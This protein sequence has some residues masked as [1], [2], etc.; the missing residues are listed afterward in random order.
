M[1]TIM[2]SVFAAGIFAIAGIANAQNTASAT[3]TANATVICPITIVNQSNLNFGNVI[4]GNGTATVTP[5]GTENY[6]GDIYAGSGSGSHS[7]AQFLV[8]GQSSA[9]Y[10]ITQTPL[11]GLLTVTDGAGH[12]A[13][14]QLT[15]PVAQAGTL[16]TLASCDGGTGGTGGDGDINHGNDGHGGTGGNGGEDNGNHGQG[17]NGNGGTGGT[18]GTGNG[19]C[20]TQTFN[21]GGVLTVAGQV[22]GNY[23]N[24]NAGGTTW[25]ETVTYN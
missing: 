17:N 23:S 8:T 5:A 22:A 12:S 25:F 2:K 16:G 11:N 1:N 24:A 4:S 10:A 7:A 18:G 3:A 15:A 20:G 21:V 9:S 19:C 14:V 13:Q 6:T